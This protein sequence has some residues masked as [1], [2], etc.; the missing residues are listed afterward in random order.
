MNLKRL[1]GTRRKKQNV[2]FVGRFCCEDGR[3]KK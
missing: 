2:Q 1:A 3:A